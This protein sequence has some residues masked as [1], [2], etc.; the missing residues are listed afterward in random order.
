[1]MSEL[2]AQLR[3]KRKL[4]LAKVNN[5]PPY[6]SQSAYIDSHTCALLATTLQFLCPVVFVFKELDG[7]ID[8][9]LTSCLHYEGYWSSS[10]A[11]AFSYGRTVRN[12]LSSHVAV[13]VESTQCLL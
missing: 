7:F 1:M 3:P 4:L 5:F 6:A 12:V 13:Y 2:S 9:W 8:Y 10:T 11:S